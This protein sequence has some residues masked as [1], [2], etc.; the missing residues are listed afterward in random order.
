MFTAS[1]DLA[2]TSIHL[3]VIYFGILDFL[4]FCFGGIDRV[5]IYLLG[6][7]VLPINQ[8]LAFLETIKTLYR[9]RTSST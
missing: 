2:A 9:A 3:S 4:S 6:F 7:M 5:L 8:Q 1:L